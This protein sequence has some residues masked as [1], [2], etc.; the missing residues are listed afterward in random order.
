[1]ADLLR[2]HDFTPHLHTIFQVGPPISMDLEL[3]EATERKDLRMESFSLIISG[4]AS[5]WLQQATYLLLHPAMGELALFLVP[6]GPREGRM[7]YESVFARLIEH[8]KAEA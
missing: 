3:I 4:Q 1:M 7:R 8:P 5:P 2:F 6:L